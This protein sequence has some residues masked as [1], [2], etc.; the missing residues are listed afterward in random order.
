MSKECN[1]IWGVFTHFFHS[2][3]IHRW[4]WD[5]FLK[6]SVSAKPSQHSPTQITSA[7]MCTHPSQ[8]LPRETGFALLRYF[9]APFS[10]HSSSPPKSSQIILSATEITAE[11]NWLYYSSV[12]VSSHTSRLTTGHHTNSW[13]SATSPTSFALLASTLHLPLHH[14]RPQAVLLSVLHHS[15]Y[16]DLKTFAFPTKIFG[17]SLKSNLNVT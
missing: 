8:L 2:V 6:L 12:D 9:R 17:F 13:K 15:L 3:N 4:F 10:E 14:D 16:K 11:E 1:Y 7:E 5:C